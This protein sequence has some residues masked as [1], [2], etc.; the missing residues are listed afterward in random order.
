[1]RLLFKRK[2]PETKRVF[3]ILRFRQKN[4]F[5]LLCVDAALSQRKLRLHRLIG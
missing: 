3:S 5:F 1:M 4:N 2:I